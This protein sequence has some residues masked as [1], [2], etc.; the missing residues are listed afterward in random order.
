VNL[1]QLYFSHQLLLIQADH[2]AS[3]DTRRVRRAAASRIACRIGK[4]QR[5][6]GAG[7]APAWEA[8][9]GAD[10]RAAG[11]MCA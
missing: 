9:C 5:Q 2:S 8:Q 3:A 1:N 6:L 11:L 10:R 7:G 4:V